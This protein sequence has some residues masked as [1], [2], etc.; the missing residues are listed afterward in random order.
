MNRKPKPDYYMRNLTLASVA[1]QAGCI[2]VIVIF[3][4]LF[5]GMF[6]DSRLD[7]RPVL[8][9]GLVLASVPVSLYA[10]V[11]VMLSSV[12]AIQQPPQSK[13]KE[14]DF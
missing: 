6:L 8:T 12:A 7:T 4:A 14:R 5:G 2:T 1:G 3:A 9:I 11:R 10:M 13:D